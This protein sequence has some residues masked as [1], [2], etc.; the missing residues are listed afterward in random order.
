M[1]GDRLSHSPEGYRFSYLFALEGFRCCLFRRR[2]RFLPL[3]YC[4]L[5]ILPGNPPSRT[6]PLYCRYINHML[7]RHL[8]GYRGNPDPVFRSVGG[9]PGRPCLAPGPHRFR[10]SGICMFGQLF[11]ET[12]IL[13][14][15]SCNKAHHAAYLC[16]APFCYKDMEKARFFSL[17]VPLRLLGLDD[18]DNGTFLNMAPFFHLP[19]HEIHIIHGHAEF[20]YHYLYCHVFI[21][22]GYLYFTLPQA[23]RTLP[24]T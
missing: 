6:R 19:F 11:P 1:L 5:D 3:L 21:L 15:C 22:P 9:S 10:R 16:L 13:F 7:F 2:R 23:P 17:N 24:T 14:L 8:A 18:K 20:W 4:L 12:F